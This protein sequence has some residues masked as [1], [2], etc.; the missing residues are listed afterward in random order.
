MGV[1]H[2]NININAKEIVSGEPFTMYIQ[3][4]DA[5]N[6]LCRD[7]LGHPHLIVD[8]GII[9]PVL[10]RGFSSGEWRGRVIVTGPGKLKVRVWERESI[11]EIEIMVVEKGAAVVFPIEIKCPGCREDNISGKADIFRCIHCN[12][13]YYVDKFGHVI[14]LKHGKHSDIGYVKHL[15]F[16]MPSDVNYL[17]HVR[18]FIVG[19]S[20]EE[21]IEEEK[22]SQ[23]EMSLDEALANVVEHAY[24]FDPYQEIQ[25]EAWL[26]SDKLEIVIR[27]H[28]RTF[29][30]KNTPLPDLKKH[31][32]ERRVGGLGRYL[33]TKFMDEV[34]YRSTG[35]TNEL[36]MVK[37]F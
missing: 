13:I 19:I 16:K 17:N 34:E 3:A 10:A 12:E 6:Q 11:G 15:E 26:Y 9:S 22:I 7:Y 1:Q 23:I 29:D 30:S 37:R 28:G 5:G 25:V 21:N 14:P 32:E 33:I 36:R 20:G 4:L 35:H 2:F 18:N 24:S 31:I 8:R 27:D